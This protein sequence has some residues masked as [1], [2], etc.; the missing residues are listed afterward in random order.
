MKSSQEKVVKRKIEKL[1]KAILSIV[2]L[3]ETEL[4]VHG[5]INGHMQRIRKILK[6][7]LEEVK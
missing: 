6:E 5:A 4:K 2:D 1:D 3:N 7:I